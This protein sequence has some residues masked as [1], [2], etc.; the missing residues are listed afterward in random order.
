MDTAP[1]V[2]KPTNQSSVVSSAG[3]EPTVPLHGGLPVG[4]PTSDGRSLPVF[5]ETPTGSSTIH[6][7]LPALVANSRSEL[8]TVIPSS[9]QAAVP[10]TP[11]ASPPSG[12]LRYTCAGSFGGCFLAEAG[13]AP[14]A[15]AMSTATTQIPAL[16]MPVRAATS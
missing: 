12:A 3:S 11:T 2:L 4:S 16:P 9:S 6:S 1:E 8:L 7:V 13:P 10:L 5:P 14:S 15:P